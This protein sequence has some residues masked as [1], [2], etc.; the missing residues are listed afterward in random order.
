[1][2]NKILCVGDAHI[3]DERPID[4]Y[5]LFS[6]LIVDEKP[7]H[8]ILMGDWLTLNCLSAWDRDKRKPMEGKRYAKEL[9]AGSKALDILLDGMVRYNKKQAKLKKRQY[10]PT[11]VYLGGN[12]EDRLTRFLDRDPTFEGSV[13]VEKDLSLAKRGFI[14]VPYRKYYYV[15]DI[16]FTHSPQ[17]G[18]RDI[19]GEDITKKASMV[20]VKSTV[21]GHSHRLE[22]SN[23]HKEGQEHLQQV[24]TCG[25]SFEKNEDYVDGKLTR[26]WKGCV[27]LHN[28][29]PSRF[30]M[31][32]Y[33]FG[34]LKRMYR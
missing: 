12:H 17:N 3:D 26:Y 24:L 31:T 23:W 2:V 27:I 4:R 8:I 33:S 19:A 28:Y 9:E 15:N 21:F 5:K 10:K 6:R 30:D 20:T 32:T 34:R 18:V 25:C 1:M 13:S 22:T 11:L 14:Y 16:G 29:K 7:T